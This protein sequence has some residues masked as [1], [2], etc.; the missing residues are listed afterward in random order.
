MKKNTFAC[1]AVLLSSLTATTVQAGYA[2]YI[3]DDV[4]ITGIYPTSN[5]EDALWIYFKPTQYTDN[6]L[7]AGTDPN[8]AS[9]VKIVTS[10][11]DGTLVMTSGS[12]NRTFS[13]ATT[14]L[15]EKKYVDIYA[16]NDATVGQSMCTNGVVGSVLLK[17]I[18][19]N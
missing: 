13:L 4:E 19:I 15:L 12:L 1:L 3:M 11:P 10:A 17:S 7:C 16:Y 9:K 6:A 8:V 5:G 14:A 2:G 18:D